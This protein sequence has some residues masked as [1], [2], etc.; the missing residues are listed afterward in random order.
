MKCASC[1]NTGTH[2]RYGA[3][4]IELFCFECFLRGYTP[5]QHGNMQAFTLENPIT[6]LDVA[7]DCPLTVSTYLHVHQLRKYEGMVIDKAGDC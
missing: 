4:K 2:I 7:I 6:A 5:R 1:D 3:T